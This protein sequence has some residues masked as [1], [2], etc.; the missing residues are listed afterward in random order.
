MAKKHKI[1]IE[2]MTCSNCAFSVERTIKKAG[3]DKVNVNFST[4]EASFTNVENIDAL[5]K[6]INKTGFQVVEGGKENWWSI[7][8]R[9]TICVIFTLPLLAH[10]FVGHDSFLNNPL[11]QLLLTIPV[12]IFGGLFFL[13]SAFHSL[14]SG[15]PNMDVLVSVGFISAFFYSIWGVFV[16]KTDAHNY[17]FFETAATI[18]TLVLLGNLLEKRAIKQTTSSLKDLES[19]KPKMARKILNGDQVEK[20]N[21]EDLQIDDFVRIN[22]GD[23][24]PIDGIIASG[25]LELDES[26]VTGESH[27][28]F[29]NTLTDVVSGTL[30]LSGSALVRVTHTSEDSTIDK[31]IDLVR[32]AQLNKPNIQKIGDRVSA[33]FVPIVIGIAILT[34]VLAYFVFDKS[35][36]QS[37]MQAIAVLVISCPCAMGLAAPTAIMVGIGKLAN[38]GVLIKGGDTIEKLAKSNLVVFDK[39]GTL[40]TGQFILNKMNYYKESEEKIKQVILSLEMQSNHPIAESLVNELKK[41]VGPIYMQDV[42]EIRGKGVKGID[43]EGNTYQLV[44]NRHAKTITSRDINSDLVLF[45]GTSVVGELWIKDQAKIDAEETISWLKSNN[46]K[47]ML[48][49]GDRRKNCEELARDLLLDDYYYEKSPEEKLKMIEKL[50]K[51]YEVMMV[52]DG[53][54]DAP[55]LALANVGVSFGAAT[56]IAINS[57]EVILV[58]KSL[59]ALKKA[60][61]VSKQTYRTIK[62]NFFWAFAYNIVAIPIAAAGYLDPMVAA[63]SM[64]FSDVVVIGNSL[65]LKAKKS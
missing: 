25:E 65:L 15:V 53:I 40:T 52:G 49:S 23:I 45:N 16:I 7:E 2:G 32:D 12:L 18:I 6:Q 35:I 55:S 43:I 29:K 13:K 10:M 31:I 51:D 37:I 58:D 38:H 50:N 5:K 57:S 47:T 64:A 21:V 63:L 56:D 22:T 9:F 62:Q 48:L 3:G 28:I 14:K 61:T 34:L 41:D 46:Y 54:N 33:I 20:V 19:L 30:V 42:I 44:S 1:N 24:V 59:E 4:G 60:L 17:L 8:K 27:P 11:L 26:L 36:E 39:T